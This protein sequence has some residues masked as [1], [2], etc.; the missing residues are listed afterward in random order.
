[1][2][3][4]PEDVMALAGAIACTHRRVLE[5]VVYRDDP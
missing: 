3:V 1:M 5:S 4:M 2:S